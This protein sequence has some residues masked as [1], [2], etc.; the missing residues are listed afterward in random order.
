MSAFDRFECSKPLSGHRNSRWTI[1]ICP[2]P[3]PAVF[4]RLLGSS[5][6]PAG[7]VLA[8]KKIVCYVLDH[9]LERRRK[10][11]WWL[12]AEI[13]AFH[14]K[15]SNFSQLTVDSGW[16]T[17]LKC[18]LQSWVRGRCCRRG[19]IALFSSWVHR[20]WARIL[21]AGV[22]PCEAWCVTTWVVP[23][24]GVLYLILIVEVCDFEWVIEQHFSLGGGGSNRSF[25]DECWIFERIEGEVEVGRVVGLMPVEYLFDS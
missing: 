10:C 22:V 8:V 16:D 18:P 17:W 6:I 14:E 3:L 4:Y 5:P 1:A 11:C 13:V 15:N 2:F 20:D 23:K 7:R 24:W 12:A 25:K 9:F 19:K 21:R